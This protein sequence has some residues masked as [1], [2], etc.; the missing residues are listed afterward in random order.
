MYSRHSLGKTPVNRVAAYP[1]AACLP[2]PSRA[3]APNIAR[4]R[5]CEFAEART[6]AV[7]RRGGARRR[8]RAARAA[9]ARARG[10]G[11]RG[12]PLLRLCQAMVGRLRPRNTPPHLSCDAA[13]TAR[14]VAARGLIA[15]ARPRAQQPPPREGSRWP[16]ELGP[17][18]PEAEGLRHPLRL[19]GGPI[20]SRSARSTRSGRSSS[21]PCPSSACSGP[22][23]ASCARSARAGCS[24]RPSTPPTSSLCSTS[25]AAT[26][27]RCGTRC[28]RARARARP[29]PP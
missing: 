20:T 3:T 4:R 12:A 8:R 7:A 9:A 13:P 5:A 6:A 21:S 11:E 17:G 26:A 25:S 2:A 16:R 10:R 24:T 27:T 28:R 19:A 22:A 14:L 29:R 18:R 15:P 1:C 23:R